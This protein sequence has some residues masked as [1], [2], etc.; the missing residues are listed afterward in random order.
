MAY[1]TKYD[2]KSWLNISIDSHDAE[3]DISLGAASNLIDDYCGRS[4][5]A[6]TGTP[7]VRYYA[8]RDAG[9]IY[10]HDFVDADGFALAVDYG[11][12]GTYTAWTSGDYQLEP[13]NNLHG[14]TTVP[15]YRI[16]ALGGK[17]FPVSGQALVQV[18]ADW[19]WDATPG[20]VKNACLVQ[21]TKFFK[22]TESPE[23]FI[24]FEGFAERVAM[25]LDRDVAMMLDGFRLPRIF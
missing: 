15:Y 18:T 4:F 22:R 24:G 1:A 21:A 20:S 14:S 3:I 11:G 5:V 9:L 12:S 10:T 2:L 25:G 13:L 7:S 6:A 23:G 8:A 17:Y 19:G 16:R